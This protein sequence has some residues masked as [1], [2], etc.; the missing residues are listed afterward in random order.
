MLD[1]V[2]ACNS[3]NVATGRNKE[4]LSAI[5]YCVHYSIV[6]YS[7]REAENPSLSLIHVYGVKTKLCIAT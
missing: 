4:I 2:H 7:N 6:S 1:L 3:L 5:L